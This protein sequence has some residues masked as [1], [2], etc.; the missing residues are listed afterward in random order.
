[1]CKLWIGKGK[2]DFS[3]S[4]RWLP[5]MW[6]GR[7]FYP[8]GRNGNLIRMPQRLFR[9]VI[10]NHKMAQWLISLALAENLGLGLSKHTMAHNHL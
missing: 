9:S 3:L 4:S 1:M 10:L 8:T 5:D 6:V 7:S 2:K